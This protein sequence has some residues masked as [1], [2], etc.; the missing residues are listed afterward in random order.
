MV[1]Q[2]RKLSLP[3][4]YQPPRRGLTRWQIVRRR[5]IA[6]LILAGLIGV[7]A[8]VLHLALNRNSH[9]SATTTMVVKPLKIVF[10]EGFTR[11]DMAA[12]IA[13]IDEIAR[14]QRGINPSLSESR[15][16]KLT[17]SSVLPGRYAGDGK[18]RMLE[19]FLFPATYEFLGSTSTDRLVSDQL[20]AFRT[21]WK[22][23]D[24]RYARSKNLTR[25][26]VLI[27]A[28]MIEKEAFSPA[29]RAKVSGV[30]YNRL[31]AHMT[32]GIDATLRYGLNLKPTKSLSP[33]LNSSSPYNTGR[34]LGLPPTPIANPGL[35][36]LQAAAH[37]DR[38]HHYLYYL[39]KPG[40]KRHYFT[41]S[42][43]DFVAHERSWGY[44]K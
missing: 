6:L 1:E 9:S 26:D 29:E 40:T 20:V 8:V 22:K 24:L 27:I 34:R 7:L 30:I 2:P 3:P 16:L 25:Y 13:S 31:H 28:S 32:L 44:I 23:L 41:S 12:R 33:F 15:Y 42:Y 37:P 5:L 18:S 4:G 19:G 17:R 11:R 43:D 35:A 36:S 14:R 39:R 38:H 21:A 10:P